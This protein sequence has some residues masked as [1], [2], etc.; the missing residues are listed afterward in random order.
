LGFLLPTYTFHQNGTM[1]L[2]ALEGDLMPRPSLPN[3]LQHNP[4]NRS[5]LD[6]LINKIS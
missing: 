4:P 5:S 1:S 2:P 3:S 6:K